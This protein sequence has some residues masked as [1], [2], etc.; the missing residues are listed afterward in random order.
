MHVSVCLACYP[1]LLLFLSLVCTVVAASILLAALLLLPCTLRFLAETSV[2]PVFP[3]S[4]LEKDSLF[5]L[6]A[7]V[8]GKSP[9]Q[10]DL[11]MLRHE[12]PASIKHSM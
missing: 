2:A 3:V 8:T 9:N 11:N 10:C 12:H 7:S 6:A 5:D 1:H 4:Q